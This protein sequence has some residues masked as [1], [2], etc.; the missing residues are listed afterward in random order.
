MRRVYVA[1][2]VLGLSVT[3]AIWLVTYRVWDV[4]RYIEYYGGKR[5]YFH[6]SEHVRV[7]PWW[8][9]PAAVAVMLTGTGISLSLLPGGRG[10]VRRLGDHFIKVAQRV[11][12]RPANGVAD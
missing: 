8:S 6:P 12:N 2:F 1:G 10:L 11:Q 7:S 5:H 3:A 4:F 9:V